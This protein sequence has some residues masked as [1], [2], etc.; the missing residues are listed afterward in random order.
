MHELYLAQSALA[1]FSS[2][3]F[4]KSVYA[5][6]RRAEGCLNLEIQFR[7]NFSL[8]FLLLHKIRNHCLL[9]LQAFR[10]LQLVLVHQAT[11]I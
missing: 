3:L 8:I 6:L 7:K 10:S 1:S 5:A 9:V 11:P 4:P 2:L